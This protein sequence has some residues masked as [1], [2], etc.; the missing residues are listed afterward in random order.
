V[1]R[2]RRRKKKDAMKEWRDG[3]R[4][5]GDSRGAG[6]T[7]CILQLTNLINSRFCAAQNDKK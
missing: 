7:K 5:M 6:I 4:M 3:A 2:H 1:E